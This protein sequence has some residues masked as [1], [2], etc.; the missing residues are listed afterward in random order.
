MKSLFAKF[1]IGPMLF[2]AGMLVGGATTGAALAERQPHMGTALATLQ[3]AAHQLG[4]A[5]HDKG[6][7]RAAALNLTNQAIAQV[8][9]GIA[10]D[11]HK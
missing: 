9:A 5:Q 2:A 8:R 4:I 11:N 7:H 10:Y 3:R 6:G 1:G